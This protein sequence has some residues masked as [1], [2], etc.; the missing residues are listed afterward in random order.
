MRAH[1]VAVQ[2]DVAINLNHIVTAGR[3]NGLVSNCGKAKP[4]VL[5]PHVP[6][7][8]GKFVLMERDEV[9]R[10][11]TGAII[12]DE[13][14]VR[15]LALRAHAAKDEVESGRPVVGSDDQ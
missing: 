2:H 13:N 14:L 8:D 5:V 9:A 10:F 11:V 12:G 4:G 15:Q 7:R 3:G 1:E 6:Q